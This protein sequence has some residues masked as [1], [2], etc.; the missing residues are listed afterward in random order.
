MR[1]LH[2]SKTILG[3]API[4]LVRALQQHTNYEVSLIDLKKWD[5]FE[6]DI[7]HEEDLEKMLETAEKADIIHLHNYL[8]YDSN[9]FYPVDF[10]ELRKKGKIF[11][12]QF[13]SEPYFVAR[14]MGKNVSDVLESSIPSLVIA[15]FQERFYPNACVV[16][17]IIPQDDQSYMPLSENPSNGISFYPTWESSAWDDRWNTKGAPET[18]SLIKNV[19]RRTGCN[20]NYLTNQSH[21]KVMQEKRRASLIIDDLVTGSYHISGLEGLSLGKTVLAF[22]DDRT[23]QV[24][25]EI[26][27]SDICPFINVRLEDALEV[28]TYLLVHPNEMA[29]IGIN[30][31]KWIEKYWADRILIQH[32]VNVYEKLLQNPELVRRQESLRLNSKISYF[33]AVTLPDIIYEA[34]KVRYQKCLPL[35]VKLEKRIRQ[36]LNNFRNFVS[37]LKQLLRR[38]K[39]FISRKLLVERK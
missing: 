22:L 5:M 34:R 25:R 20:I 31:R 7:I 1:I 10:N 16:P 9:D 2:F 30:S 29:E 33:L 39:R 24:L 17:N 6:Q 14:I 23:Q 26:S 3:G 28:M 27:G 38:I 37:Q 4:R 12:R 21:V 15:Q 8:D 32:F 35:G 36:S 11:V 18:L 19:A 13:H